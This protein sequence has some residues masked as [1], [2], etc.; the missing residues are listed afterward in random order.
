MDL[1]GGKWAIHPTEPKI[2]I[3]KDKVMEVLEIPEIAPKNYPN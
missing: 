1:Q 2:A 3:V